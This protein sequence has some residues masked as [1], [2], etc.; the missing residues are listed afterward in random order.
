L[1]CYERN[2]DA[3]IHSIEIELQMSGDAKAVFHALEK[4]SEFLK[5]HE[6]EL[7][8]ASIHNCEY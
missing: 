4:L 7:V 1:N 5:E 3:M 2:G 6:L 8:K